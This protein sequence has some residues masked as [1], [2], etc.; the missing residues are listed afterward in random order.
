MNA[1]RC[2]LVAL[3]ILALGLYCT[4]VH[5]GDPAPAPGSP[6]A[7]GVPPDEVVGPSS[8]PVPHTAG[9]IREAVLEAVSADGARLRIS[10][11]GPARPFLFQLDH[12]DRV[13]LDLIGAETAAALSWSGERGFVREARWGTRESR[14]GEPVVRYVIET[15]GPAD[16]ALASL[17]SGL[18]LDVTRKAGTSAA[19]IQAGTSEPGT[20]ETGTSEA[21]VGETGTA[22]AVMSERAR[23][24]DAPPAEDK[25]APTTPVSHAALAR[26]VLAGRTSEEQAST[27]IPDAG[28]AVSAG[29]EETYA[30]MRPSTPAPSPTASRFPFETAWPVETAWPGRTAPVAQT[31][32]L[33]GTTL[34]VTAAPEAGA[35]TMGDAAPEAMSEALSEV[36]AAVATELP[37]TETWAPEEEI[38]PADFRV[39][40]LDAPG[41]AGAGLIARSEPLGRETAGDPRPFE[42]SESLPPFSLD[43]QG[44]DIHTVLRSIAEY[45]GINIVADNNVSGTLTIRALDL[46]WPEMLDAVCRA[47]G[48]V[49]EEHGSVVRIASQKTAREE[50]LAVESAARKQEEYMP[51]LTRVVLVDYANAKEL[52]ETL[53]KITSTRGHV[54][55]DP[56]TNALILTDIAPR[57]EE[58]EAMIHRLDSETVQVEIAAKIV[59]V[60]ETAARELGISWSI[61]D[62]HSSSA[63]AS[64][65]IQQLTD[66]ILDPANEVRVGVI[67]SFGEIQAK[68]QALEQSNEAEIISAP[69]ITT[70]DNR[71]AR[72]LV[73]KEVPLIT[74]DFAGNAITELKKVGITLEVTPHVNANELITMD[75]H[76]EVSDLSSQSTAQGGVVFTTTE[77]DTRVMVDNG[78]TAVIAGLIRSSE[79]EYERGVP[80]LRSIPV[81][82]HLFKSTNKRAE[83][84]EML[85]FITPRLMDPTA[86]RG[87]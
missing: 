30:W 12:P 41:E 33:S 52:Q 63:N 78:E 37:P 22:R 67:R 70:V 44:A 48:L 68:L 40:G 7:A 59:D 21:A 60:D 76:P 19:A 62:L 35:K 74:L 83:K 31:L 50:A 61:E 47:S 15:A 85:I 87:Q 84:R 69:R 57:L 80:Y 8:D 51:L 86:S 46:P 77:A 10:T 82:G 39:A 81:L 71:L 54:E 16:C 43:V 58:L 55:F 65:N 73:G 32:P 29:G 36:E 13:V 11:E 34:P 45:A 75:I 49:Y 9:S 1:E 20:V 18:C 17:G 56:R 3:L 23:P 28:R 38:E 24:T 42:R 72:I 27:S 4:P 25:P 66:D 14:R 5:A 26:E 2:A 79:I 6:A 64:G 53:S